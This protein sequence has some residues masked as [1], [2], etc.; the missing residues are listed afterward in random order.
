MWI[1]LTGQTKR[2]AGV[3]GTVTVPAGCVILEVAAHSSGAATVTLPDGKG[4]TLTLPVPSTGYG[5]APK[6]ALCIVNA[7][8]DIVFSGTDGYFVELY[9][10]R[11][12]L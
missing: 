6:H 7:A 4:G 8:F 12:Q 9:G 3:S 1:D 11:G 10:D 5:Y 2:F